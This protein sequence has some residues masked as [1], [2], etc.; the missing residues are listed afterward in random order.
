MR[1]EMEKTYNPKEAEDRIYANWL[2]KGYFQAKPNPDKEPFTLVIPP[3]NITGQMHMGH[4]LDC[5]LQDILVRFKRMQ[6]RETLWLPGTDHASIA[7]EAMIVKDMAA[8][9]LSKEDLGRDGFLKRAW[10]WYDKYGSRIVTQLKKMGSSCDW[11]KLRFTMDEG[12]SDAVTEFFI[13]LYEKGYIYRGEKL[14]NWCSHCKTTISDAEVEHSDRES[15]LYYIQYPIKGTD[16]FIKFATTRPET[17]LADV[18]V[19]VSPGDPRY[20]DLIGKTAIVPFVNRE[21]K[22]IADEYVDPEYGTGAVKITPGHD[23]ND[24]AVGE[25][26]NLPLINILNDDGTLGPGTVVYEGLSEKEAR[27]RIVKD[28]E[29]LGLFIKDEKLIHSVGSHD[30]CDTV[31]DP[32]LKTQWFV[33]ME[34]LARPALKAFKSG[35]LKIFP[36]RF[37]KI[38]SHWL[39]NIRDWCISRQL[40][41]GHRI[42]AWHCSCGE[43]MVARQTPAACSACN[44][45]A[46]SQ[47]EDVLDTWFSSALWPFSTLGWPEKT[48]EYNYFYP[49]N[50][51]IMGWEILF[52]WGVRMVVAGLELTGELPYKDM[53]F[54]GI[55]RDANGVKMSKSLGNGIDPLDLID[56]YGTDALRFSLIIGNT[57]GE[58]FRFREE[59]ITGCRNF[60]N[61]I[62]NAARFLMMNT[63]DEFADNGVYDL[64]DADKWLISSSN[65]LIREVTASLEAYDKGLAASKV[66]DFIWSEF[67]D[68]AIEMAKPRLLVKDLAAIWTLRKV[69]FDA[70]RLLHPFMP[71]ITEEVF[72]SLQLNEETITHSPWPV[73]READNNES[74][75]RAIQAVK[76][77]VKAVRAIRVEKDVPPSRKTALHIVASSPENRAVFNRG[78]SYLKTLSFADQVSITDTMSELTE[79]AISAVIPGAVIYI[80]LFDLVDAEKEKAR[81]EK[82]KTRLLGEVA[83]GEA[84]LSNKGFTDKAPQTLIDTEK[85]KLAEYREMLEKVEAEIGRY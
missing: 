51:I 29:A 73:Y 1:K 69:F 30:R 72:Q 19:A 85:A 39:T 53:I 31:V 61:K 50:T 37:G 26:H 40:W 68:W 82:E 57:P 3:P 41:W 75:E 20:A 8:E 21:I 10:K 48:P 42:P 63:P 66:H 54:H 67:C 43:I 11:D 24:F 65:R 45:P 13:R 12:L 80:P 2:E 70:M 56:Q 78:L 23:H 22:I 38:Y 15:A 55:V 64:T 59:K 44:S 16:K 52:F 76:D 35:E 36:D 17:I 58:D 79:N 4:A 84:K 7:T 81:L 5:T 6:G 14:C 62:W 32:R 18:A 71:F 49:T 27:A 33:R 34:E 60:C 46:L 28:L 9:D 74:E 25:R 83:R 77:A 47:D